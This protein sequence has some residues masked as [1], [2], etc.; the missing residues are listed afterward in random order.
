M[1]IRFTFFLVIERTILL[2]IDLC[3]LRH[4]NILRV[5]STVQVLNRPH[6]QQFQ[7][8]FNICRMKILSLIYLFFSI[9][10]MNITTKYYVT[11][12]C[13]L[14]VERNRNV[15]VLGGFN[16]SETVIFQCIL[17]SCL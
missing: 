11:S 17:I 3:P 5:Y 2:L 15:T 4:F 9:I 6:L 8:L 16:S 1:K 13:M 12:W 7:F 10:N 14:S